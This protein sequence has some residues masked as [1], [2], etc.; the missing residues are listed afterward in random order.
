MIEKTSQV[1]TEKGVR[2]SAQREIIYE[3]LKST[4]SHPDVDA[5][6]NEVKRRLPDIGVATVYRNLKKL[7]ATGKVNTLETTKDCI[8]YDADISNHAHFVCSRCGKIKD[9]FI[10]SALTDEVENLGYKVEREKLVFYGVCPDC[11]KK[12]KAD[13]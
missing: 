1:N 8:H 9:V 2:H 5:I 4:T 7:V 6:Y 10:A 12:D 13:A 3:T 11:I